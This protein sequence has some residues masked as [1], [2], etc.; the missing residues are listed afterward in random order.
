MPRF[1]QGDRFTKPGYNVVLFTIQRVLTEKECEELQ[2]FHNRNNEYMY[3]ASPNGG[4]FTEK[5]LIENY[6]LLSTVNYNRVWEQINV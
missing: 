6:K 3:Y 1:K 4:Y 5:Y 2:L